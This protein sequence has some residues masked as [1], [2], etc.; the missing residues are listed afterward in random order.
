M[1]LIFVFIVCIFSSLGLGKDDSFITIE[2]YGGDLYKNPRGIGCV[3]C[4]G[5]D[6]RGK[7]IATYKHKGQIKVLVGPDIT[8]LDFEN[9]YRKTL[10]DKGVMPKYHLTDEEI[11]AIYVYL[12][13]KNSHNQPSDLKNLSQED[14]QNADKEELE[15]KSPNEPFR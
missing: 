6:G 4:H 13:S 8:H 1:R 12:R 3:Y 14:E 5:E 7:Q 10:T 2:E 15:E 11:R 9:F